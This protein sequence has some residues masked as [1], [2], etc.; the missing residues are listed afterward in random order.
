MMSERWI[1]TIVASLG[2]LVAVPNPCSAQD[3][4]PADVLR[5][6]SVPERDT[7]TLVHGGMT[8]QFR[9]VEGRPEAAA[10]QLLDLDDATRR[11]AE[12]IV[13]ERSMSVAMLLV[14]QIDTVRQITDAIEQGRPEQA[15]ELLVG[16]RAR[17]EPDLPRDPL[18]EPL[19]DLLSPEQR[20]RFEHLLDEYWNAWIDSQL[21]GRP[22]DGDP[23]SA[24]AAR[25]RIADRLSFQLFQEEIREGYEV[26]LRRYRQVLEGIYEAVD[27]TPE[28]REAIRDVVIE[29]IRQTRLSATPTQRRQAMLR[30]YRL[31][32]E[33]RRQS[34]FMH[35]MRQVVPDS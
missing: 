26:T 29:H 19:A 20:A 6:P 31:L 10:V 32:D 16:L 11:R 18:A 25:Q 1:I 22:A 2:A 12:E 24:R 28:Q 17:F 9:R 23:A 8:G 33:D 13:A 7:R 4:D 5:G 14:D 21:P 34:L 35:I 3:E 27:P 15:R 30:I